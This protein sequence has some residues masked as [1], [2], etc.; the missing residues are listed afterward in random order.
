MIKKTKCF[1]L[2]LGCYLFAAAGPANAEIPGFGDDGLP[3]VCWT[4]PSLMSRFQENHV[5]RAIN[6]TEMRDRIVDLY[7]KRL[8]PA[9][10]LLLKNE[11]LAL[12]TYLSGLIKE[13]EMGRCEQLHDLQEA[14]CMA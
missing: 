2:F 13:V 1:A 7:E 10:V 9:K 4:L 11:H 6:P 12:R 3:L 8:D 5:S 14:N